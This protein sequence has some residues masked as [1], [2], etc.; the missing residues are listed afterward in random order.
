MWR[1][2]S[3]EHVAVQGI[4]GAAALLLGGGFRKRR[5][6]AEYLAQA[7]TRRS[8]LL[9]LRHL[10][11]LLLHGLGV[12][13]TVLKIVG[14]L[15]RDPALRGVG[16]DIFDHL[17]FGLAETLDQLAG[18]SRR[19]MPFARGL[20]QLAALFRVFPQRQEPLHALVGRTR[21]WR[22]SRRA[23]ERAANR[24][25][26]V[27]GKRTGS[28]ADGSGRRGAVH[29]RKRRIVPRRRLAGQRR[30]KR[31][32]RQHLA[33]VERNDG[34]GEWHNQAADDQSCFSG[35]VQWG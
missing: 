2:S 20:D 35:K 19:R 4:E 8:L 21:R 18:F 10:A 12:L 22:G 34:H 24:R 11:D 1:W 26:T 5:R 25:R 15:R 27:G 32:L 31:A 28:S 13:V 30:R 7:R 23:L 6:R 9:L 3:R 14:D 29:R 17:G 33:G 16:F